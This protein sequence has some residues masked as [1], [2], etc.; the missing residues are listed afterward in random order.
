MPEAHGAGARRRPGVAHIRT[1][2]RH[3][4]SLSWL[5]LAQLGRPPRQLDWGPARQRMHPSKIQAKPHAPSGLCGHRVQSRPRM[6]VQP[7]THVHGSRTLLRLGRRRRRRRRG[8]LQRR[9]RRDAGP[10]RVGQALER[11]GGRVRARAHHRLVPRRRRRLVQV[12]RRACRARACVTR[13]PQPRENGRAGTYASHSERRP[14]APP[15]QW[16]SGRGAAGLPRAHDS[17]TLPS[18]PAL[19]V[20]RAHAGAPRG[21][22]R[23]W[24]RRRDG[25]GR[26]RAAHLWRGISRRP[27]DPRAAA[28]PPSSGSRRRCRPGGPGPARGG[29]AGSGPGAKAGVGGRV[30][31][32]AWRIRHAAAP[33]PARSARPPRRRAPAAAPAA[34]RPRRPGRRAGRS[35]AGR[36]PPAATTG[37]P[38]AP[39][40]AHG[41][42]QISRVHKWLAHRD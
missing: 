39:G 22:S 14:A 15:G 3:A 1:Q 16:A 38:P 17:L 37:R 4:G 34:R 7:R 31:F 11:P 20:G 19:A 41:A 18:E 32:R 28:T 23:G 6:A 13:P 25:G 26:M 40:A 36:P 2:A 10:L 21:G 27:P 35:R 24:G 5:T 42:S 8:R 29:A 12:R 9:V 33:L 30:R